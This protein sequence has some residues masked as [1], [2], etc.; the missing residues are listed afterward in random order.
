MRADRNAKERT[1]EQLARHQANRNQPE[2]TGEL[3]LDC[4]ICWSWPNESDVCY[5]LACD[6]CGGDDRYA[7]G[8]VVP[9]PDG[10]CRCPECR[11]RRKALHRGRW[12]ETQAT[13]SQSTRQESPK[14][15]CISDGFGR[16]TVQLGSNDRVAVCD[17]LGWPDEKPI[18]LPGLGRGM[19]DLPTGVLLAVGL[20]ELESLRGIIYHVRMA[21]L[22][23]PEP[24]TLPWLEAGWAGLLGLREGLLKMEHLRDMELL[25]SPAPMRI[26][27]RLSDVR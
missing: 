9:G 3:D 7:P 16:F 11:E 26:C 12:P 27:H 10:V 20:A 14:T 19:A 4:P 22:L 23:E 17:T 5:F 21:L 18:V 15:E 25:G 6:I 8:T 13:V 24:V 2:T 1:P